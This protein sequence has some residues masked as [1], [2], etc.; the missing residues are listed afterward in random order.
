[1]EITNAK[2]E[3][4]CR[5]HSAKLTVSHAAL[6]TKTLELGS[7]ANMQV[8]PLEGAFLGTMARAV[9]AKNILEIGTFTGYSAMTFAGAIP[10]D[11]RVTTLDID[12][13]TTAI[14][15]NFWN[16]A[17]LEHKIEL[18][19]GDARKTLVQL[20]TDILSKKRP[21]Y[22]LVFIDADKPGYSEYWNACIDLV[23]LGGVLL[24]DNVL[25]S[26]KILNPKDE[27]DLAIA[28]FNELAKNDPRIFQV[29]LPVRDGVLF[30]VKTTIAAKEQIAEK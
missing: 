8:G 21:P 9:Q 7:L 17:G 1:M 11:G 3:D 14:A 5:A 2:I 24:V 25:W 18:I 23:R 27:A 10:N 28:E 19:L 6:A 20:K 16:H 26:G 30:A 4:Y 12:P 15:K 22:D 29:M 13:D